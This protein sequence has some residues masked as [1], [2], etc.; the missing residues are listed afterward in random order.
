VSAVE[1]R[2]LRW[3][4]EIELAVEAQ[5]ASRD[6]VFEAEG[7]RVF[8]RLSMQRMAALHAQGQAQWYGAFVG[9]TL[10]A[11]CGLVHDAALGR[12]QYVQTHPQWR[13]RGLCR[14]LVAAVCRDAFERLGLSRLV[15]CADPHDV[16][17]GIYRSVGFRQVETHWCLQRRPLPAA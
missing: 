12:F 7:Y 9:A 11:D 8:R 10:V 6:A 2:R 14:A 4:E 13:R 16:A 17:I 3:P 15:M 5:V 1:I